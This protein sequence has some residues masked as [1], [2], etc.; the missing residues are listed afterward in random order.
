MKNKNRLKEYIFITA[1]TALAVVTFLVHVVLREKWKDLEE[2]VRVARTNADVLERFNRI[3]LEL[4]FLR[5]QPFK[6]EKAGV[7]A[8]SALTSIQN[9]QNLVDALKNEALIQQVEIL[10]QERLQYVYKGTEAE[11]ADKELEA[12]TKKDKKLEFLNDLSKPNIE[13]AKFEKDLA[14]TWLDPSNIAT[15]MEEQ[16]KRQYEEYKLVS[17]FL[18]PLG[19]LLNLIGRFTGLGE[20]NPE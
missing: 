20:V 12:A 15:N 3:Q 1:G 19:F 5:T 14:Q 16:S 7:T 6:P 4:A 9:L 17:C 10:E 13:P 2:N 11:Q 8:G 18:Y